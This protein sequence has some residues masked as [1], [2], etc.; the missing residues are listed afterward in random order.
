MSERTAT[1]IGWRVAQ[2]RGEGAVRQ[3]PGRAHRGRRRRSAGSRGK[4]ASMRPPRGTTTRRWSSRP[5]TPLGTTLTGPARSA[6]RA[7]AAAVELLVERDP[8]PGHE[9]AAGRD[10]RQAQL[11]EL[12]QARHR[13]RRHRRPRLAVA[14]VAGERL[15]ARR[16]PRR[17]AAPVPVASTTV[18]RKRTFLPIGVHQQRAVRAEGRGERQAGEPAA[19]P[20][21]QQ[22]GRRRAPRGAARRPGSPGRGG[23]RRRRARGSPS[24]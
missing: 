1:R 3:A 14:R 20:E 7:P 13:A 24:G 12:G 21:V 17:P 8:L 19:R 11:H 4:R 16:A 23:G 10:E 15:R 9:H 18:C 22:A 5:G 2:R 6:A